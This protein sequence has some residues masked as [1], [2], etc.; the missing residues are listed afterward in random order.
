MTKENGI[1]REYYD[2]GQ[3]KVEVVN[4]QIE[5]NWSVNGRLK[6]EIKFE[7]DCLEPN[8]ISVTARI[9]QMGREIKTH[10]INISTNLQIH[11]SIK[12]IKSGLTYTENF[13]CFDKALDD[14][15]LLVTEH[16]PTGL[17]LS[18]YAFKKFYSSKS[19]KAFCVKNTLLGSVVR[20]TGFD[21]FREVLVKCKPVSNTAGGLF[22]WKQGK[23][24]KHYSEE[25][26]GG[27][28]KCDEYHNDKRVSQSWYYVNGQK[29]KEI[30]YPHNTLTPMSRHWDVTGRE[31]D[32]NY[33]KDAKRRNLVLLGKF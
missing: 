17:S 18:R 23:I 20:G 25:F 3:L 28:K 7:P 29:R 12:Y 22:F 4:N 13:F 32:N 16:H 15:S 1:Y 2:N 21:L 5:K 6:S 10:A 11:Q 19:G 33:A 31:E 14:Y 9:V 24:L 8:D 26:L 30:L 27:V